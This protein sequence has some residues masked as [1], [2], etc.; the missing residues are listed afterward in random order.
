MINYQRIIKDCFWD[1][2]ISKN[3]ICAILKS[4]NIREKKYLFE[5]ILLNSTK[6]FVDLSIFTI[7]EIKDFTETYKVPQFNNQYIFRR[8]NLVE[9]FFLDKPLLIEELKWI[10]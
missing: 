2:N 3:D 8:K 6:L 5:K 9:V 1:S 4:D 10:V 7:K